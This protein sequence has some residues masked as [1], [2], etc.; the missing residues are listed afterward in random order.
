MDGSSLDIDI[1]ASYL[2]EIIKHID[3]P[4][5]TIGF[6]GPYAPISVRAQANAGGEES[7]PLYLLMPLRIS[8][9]A[10]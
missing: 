8:A 10:A 2:A 5:V 9:K 1:N 3:A 4:R 6:A 7:G